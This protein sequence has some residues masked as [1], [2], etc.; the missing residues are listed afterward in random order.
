LGLLGLKWG[1]SKSFSEVLGFLNMGLGF[2]NIFLHIVP[3]LLNSKMGDH[4]S[5]EL[6]RLIAYLVRR[7]VNFNI[8]HLGRNF[9]NICIKVA[10]ACW[11]W[12]RASWT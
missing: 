9:L 10:Q 1:L 6:K 3:M 8:L 4:E 5:F 7:Y 12:A 2:L 11:V